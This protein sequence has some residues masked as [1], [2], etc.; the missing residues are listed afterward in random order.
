MS[1]ENSTK[2]CRI[3]FAEHN[4]R[5]TARSRSK[6]CTNG[7]AIDK[8]GRLISRANAVRIGGDEKLSLKEPPCRPTDPGI[9]ERHVEA[10]HDRVRN[11]FGILCS[12][13]EAGT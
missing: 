12:E 1:M 13:F 7:S 4:V 8:H 6:H 11:V 9:N 2:H 3:G 5:R 10:D